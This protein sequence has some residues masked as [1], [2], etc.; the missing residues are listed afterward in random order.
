[1]LFTTLLVVRSQKNKYCRV[2]SVKENDENFENS[3]K[4][5]ICDNIYIKGD[6]S[7][8]ARIRQIQS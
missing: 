3:S 5:W 2:K 4:C 8:Q 1:M 6:A 7:K